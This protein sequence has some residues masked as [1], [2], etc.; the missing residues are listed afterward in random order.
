MPFTYKIL[1]YFTKLVGAKPFYDI[2][3]FFELTILGLI[4]NGFF[5]TIPVAIVLALKFGIIPIEMLENNRRY[6]YVGLLIFTAIIT[7]D[8]TPVSML[9]LSIPFIILMEISILIGKRVAPR[10]E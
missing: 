8:P 1:I 6:I 3:D 4:L 7:P 5:F 10:M 2:N 9:L